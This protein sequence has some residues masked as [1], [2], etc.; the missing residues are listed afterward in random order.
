MTNFFKK[1]YLITIEFKITLLLSQLIN[2]FSQPKILVT[3]I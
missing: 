3:N 2:Q 1:T